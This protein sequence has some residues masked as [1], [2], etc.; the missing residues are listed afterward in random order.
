VGRTARLGMFLSHPGNAEV[1]LS[2]S[3]S[4]PTSPASPHKTLSLVT[5]ESGCVWVWHNIHSSGLQG[6]QRQE[7]V[8]SLVSSWTQECPDLPTQS[9]WSKG[10]HP[11]LE[12]ARTRWGTAQ[13]HLVWPLIKQQEKT[14]AKK[15]AVRTGQGHSAVSGRAR[16]Q[17][18]HLRPQPGFLDDT[19]SHRV[20]NHRSKVV[21]A[22]MALMKLS[23]TEPFPKSRNQ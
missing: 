20:N 15:E 6:S 21:P 8:G 13:G 16:R 19:A 7:Y 18:P 5:R 11:S 3:R 12:N 9:H 2:Q 23:I 22:H 1:R 14:R 4:C 17:C 10:L